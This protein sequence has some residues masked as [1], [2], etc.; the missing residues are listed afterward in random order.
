MADTRYYYT[1]TER[2]FIENLP[3]PLIVSQYYDGFYHIIALSKAMQE[4]MRWSDAKWES[5]IFMDIPKELTAK[6]K[7]KE[8]RLEGNA[9]HVERADS[10]LWYVTFSDTVKQKKRFSLQSSRFNFRRGMFDR[11]LDTT[12]DCVFWKD[13]DR[14]FVGVNKAFLNAYGLD[15]ADVL[16]GKTDEDMGW[17]PDPEPFKKD[18]L[19]V[20]A[21]KSTRLVRGQCV[22]RG[23]TREILA[24]K[25]PLYEG[26][27]IVGLVGSFID[28]T[29]QVE[30]DKEN[31]KLV[32]EREI[33]LLEAEQAKDTMSQFIMR[34]SHE[35]RTPLNAILGFTQLAEGV[36]DPDVLTDYMQ[37]IK[38]SG[39]I[40][41]DLVNDILDIRKMEDGSMQLNPKPMVLTDLL[42]DLGNMVGILAQSK[43]LNF[44]MEIGEMPHEFV[45]CDKV[46]LQ[47]VMMNL[48]NNAVKFTDEGGTVSLRV[49]EQSVREGLS[50]YIFVVQDDGCGMG[51]EFIERIF[52]P[53]AQENR[54]VAKY[55]VGTGL[56]L[57]ITKRVVD[58]MHGTI[59]VES[60]ENFG[61][62]FTVRLPLTLSDDQEY[63]SIVGETELEADSAYSIAGKR[64]LVVEDNLINQEVIRGMLEVE[65][66]LCDVADDGDMALEM[67]GDSAPGYYEAVLMDIHLPGMN[68]Y[69]VTRKLRDM[70][71]PDAKT[72]PILAM[73]AE[74]VDEVVRESRASGMNDYLPKPIDMKRLK[75]ILQT[76][77]NFK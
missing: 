43:K 74:V 8:V 33:A 51:P 7:G 50:E 21:G 72:I 11:I 24:S 41:A 58:M 40:L 35:M 28:V 15:S 75:Q 30:Q 36:R 17:H 13:K 12:Q 29:D 66:L 39:N 18:E 69:E 19:E 61:S 77:L 31:E 34:A 10:L 73:S 5:L 64:L 65:E 22:I 57:N 54:D 23:R 52:Q 9:F 3:V 27:K 37:K 45:L 38:V 71:R 2:N 70:H 68:G 6:V 20:L 67:F 4:L 59:E 32:E 42:R 48:L 16:I 25:S 62:M 76:Y 46:R 63:H 44:V 56:G 49:N 55:G 14:R 53:F 26:D 47:Q 1:D 60:V